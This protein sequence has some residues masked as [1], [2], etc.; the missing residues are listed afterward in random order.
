[1]VVTKNASSV[2][3]NLRWYHIRLYF[4]TE[5]ADPLDPLRHIK[6]LGCI[7]IC[8]LNYLQSHST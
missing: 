8:V 3:E 5:V 4:G 7:F 2:R 1:M 6:G